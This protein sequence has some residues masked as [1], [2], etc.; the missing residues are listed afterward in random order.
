MH[1][2]AA[3]VTSEWTSWG[4][5]IQIA[6]ECAFKQRRNRSVVTPAANGGA[7]CGDL[8]ELR[9]CDEGGELTHDPACSKRTYIFPSTPH[10]PLAFTHTSCTPTLCTRTHNS[11]LRHQRVECLGRLQGKAWRL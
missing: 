11:R 9:A 1:D 8:T 5:C 10:L 7:E 4:S 3:C 2:T 6:G